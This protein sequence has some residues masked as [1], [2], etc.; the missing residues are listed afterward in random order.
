MD[1]IFCMIRDGKIPSQKVFENETILA[2]RDVNP[3][4]KVHILVIPKE[5]IPS[6]DAIG[7]DNAAVV[8]EIF[9]RIPQ[10][11]AEAGLEQGYRVITNC[12][13]HACQSVKHLHFHV[14]GGQQLSEK[15]C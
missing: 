8:A 3:Q 11:A 7:A 4:A 12:G 2:F 13:E 6:C 14:I 15:M 5:H 1:C 9:T 10:I